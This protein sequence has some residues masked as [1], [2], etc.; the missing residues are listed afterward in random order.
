MSL[1]PEE[2]SVDS[3]LVVLRSG[4]LRLEIATAPFELTL[5]RGGGGCGRSAG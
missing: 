1:G 4:S 3:D 2:P 5:Y